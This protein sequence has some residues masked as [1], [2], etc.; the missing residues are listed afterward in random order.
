M[1]W[2]REY[3]NTLIWINYEIIIIINT[4]HYNITSF[5][6]LQTVKQ[7]SF[8]GVLSQVKSELYAGQLIYLYVTS[9]TVHVATILFQ[10]VS[11]RGL[12]KCIPTDA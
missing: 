10:W 3:W 5:F 1:G 7:D 11:I 12:W 6:M 9:T 2:M 8:P 4:K